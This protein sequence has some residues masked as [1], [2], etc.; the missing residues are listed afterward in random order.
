MLNLEEMVEI[1]GRDDLSPLHALNDILLAKGFEDIG[2]YIRSV[3]PTLFL[4]KSNNMLETDFFNNWKN[5]NGSSIVF[6]YSTFAHK[7]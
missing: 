2:I 7:T 6:I 1:S 3:S 5:L 4:F